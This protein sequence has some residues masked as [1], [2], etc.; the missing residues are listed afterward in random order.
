MSLTANPA[1]TPHKLSGIIGPASAMGSMIT[2]QFG[3]AYAVPVML[4]HGSFGITAMRMVFAALVMLLLA[5]P[6]F[7][8]FTKAQWLG[9]AA[10]GT[11]M[12]IMTLS[13]FEAVTLI[14]IGPAITIDF[15][16]PLAVSIV[17]LKGWSRIALPLLAVCG[18]AAISYSAGGWLFNPLGILFD[19]ISACCWAAY[20]VLMR[21][22]GRLFSKHDG[23]CLSLLIAAVLASII[24]A[25]LKPSEIIL[26]ELPTAA[27]LAILAPL[28]PFSLEMIA[29]RRMDMGTF[30]ILTSLEPAFGSILGFLLLGQIL[31]PQQIAGVLAVMAASAV[32]VYF[33]AFKK[34][35]PANAAPPL[36]QYSVKLNR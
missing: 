16:G 14:P 33:S 27:G 9:A 19:L 22:V 5:R 17:A 35:A 36:E 26:A 31:S 3:V 34:P 24:V 10:L 13:Y 11:A 4:A 21:H 7:R 15:L 32:A 23:L 8:Q 6:K 30:S 29:L 25:V 2:V 1:S 28:I 12:A 20:I 18:V